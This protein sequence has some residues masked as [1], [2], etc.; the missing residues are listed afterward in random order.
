MR[1]VRSCLALALA[2]AVGACG[3]NEPVDRE[4]PETVLGPITV[5]YS[6][7]VVGTLQKPLLSYTDADGTV[8]TVVDERSFPSSPFR[9]RLPP[10]AT[11]DF[12]IAVG[13]NLTGSGL[14]RTRIRATQ[15]VTR[16][17]EDPSIADIGTDAADDSPDG[18]SSAV[19]ARSELTVAPVSVN[20]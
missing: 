15:E 4:V 5:E 1:A 11:G 9:L 12:F 3:T 19:R 14:V 20:D 17:G 7:S 2:V 10:N 8:V 16:P 13:G 18:A 6:F